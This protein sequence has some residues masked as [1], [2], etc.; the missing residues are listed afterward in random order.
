MMY[1]GRGGVRKPNKVLDE[2][3]LFDFL[4][5]PNK[6]WEDEGISIET[7]RTYD[8]GFDILTKRITVPVRNKFGQLV[9]VKGR[10]LL[11][12]DVNESDPKYIYI[13]KCNQ[14]QE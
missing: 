10:M 9:G 11:D 3:I 13:Y 8:I 4:D 1:K 6:M 5:L 2:N 7:Q 14:S 12:K